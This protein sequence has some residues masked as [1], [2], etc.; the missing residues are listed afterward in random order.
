[1]G[2]DETLPE[3]PGFEV[4]EQ[5]ATGGRA[6]IYLARDRRRGSELVALKFLR[7]EDMGRADRIRD[8]ADEVKRSCQLEHPTIV[9]VFDGEVTRGRP[10]LVMELVD[11]VTLWEL[12]KRANRA[13]KTLPY[14]L[15]AYFAAMVADALA[16]AHGLKGRDGKSLN[17]VHRDVST[18]NV[19]VTFD[20]AV[21]LL[22]F[23]IA[24]SRIRSEL[25]KPGII[26]GKLD[27]LSP[28][29]CQSGT[30]DAKTDIYA[31]GVVLFELVTGTRPFKD[32]VIANLF[33]KVCAGERELVRSIRP[34]VP[35]RLEGIIDKA[36]EVDPSRRYS[37]A[38]AMHDALRAFMERL[39]ERPTSS[40][41]AAFLASIAA[42]D[43]G[44]VQ[45]TYGAPDTTAVTAVDS[46]A[47]S[48][49]PPVPGLPP[50]VPASPDEESSVEPHDTLHHKTVEDEGTAGG[51]SMVAPCERRPRLVLPLFGG[52]M[53]L[54]LLSGV[55]VARLARSP[56]EASGGEAGEAALSV[57]H[58]IDSAPSPL[59]TSPL[60][61]PRDAGNHELD[62][63]A[64]GE[65][66]DVANA[67]P[68]DGVGEDDS[69]E[70][71]SGILD[72]AG[73]FD[74]SVEGESGWITVTTRRRAALFIRGRRVG[75]T[76]VEHFALPP[77]RYRIKVRSRFGVRRRWVTVSA[78]D[79]KRLSFNL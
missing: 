40:G 69:P 61:P 2:K 12:C 60:A 35:P 63:A 45:A 76:P 31:L 13:K 56:E 58:H 42:E 10:Y 32:D 67:G 54:A 64:S 7:E 26:K 8:F 34:D 79:E 39:P 38:K 6:E 33:D 11:G 21:K 57:M 52:L 37:S 3:I 44:R 66:A 46:G 5:L 75:L 19:M 70:Q 1:M 71:D 53:V 4:L 49:S 50:A 73:L 72:F 16:Y 18:V 23:G 28:E 25:T 78:G 29:Q 24:R 36:M 68:T 43:V 41:V 55:C 51:A 77:G 48:K 59:P 62:F 15:A 14:G 17:L 74:G 30:L 47:S 9:R 22:D 65:S 27:Y 20:G